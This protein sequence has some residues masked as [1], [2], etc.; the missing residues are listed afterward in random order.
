MIRRET[1]AAAY[2]INKKY[3]SLIYRSKA[4]KT[5]YIVI[6]F[7]RKLIKNFPS[8]YNFLGDKV[9]KF[10]AGCLKIRAICRAEAVF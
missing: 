1:A 9:P 10:G 6:M 5:P 4:H 2:L 3:F 8:L 7:S